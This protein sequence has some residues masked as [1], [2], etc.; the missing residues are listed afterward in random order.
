MTSGG[1]AISKYHDTTEI[2]NKPDTLLKQPIRPVRRD[3]MDACL[4]HF[5]EKCP[6]SHAVTSQGRLLRVSVITCAGP[7]KIL[8][9]ISALSFRR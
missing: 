1:F 7:W 8:R 3:A 2:Y 4:K 9:K 5:D 6:K